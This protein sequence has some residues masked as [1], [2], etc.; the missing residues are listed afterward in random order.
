ADS[1]EC[2]LA[3]DGLDPRNVL[4][5]A[6]H[7]LQTF[8]L[9][10]VQLELQLKELV[11]EIALLVPQLVI[12]QVPY[13]FCFHNRFLNFSSATCLRASQT[14]CARA[15]CATPDAW[16]RLRPGA[17]HLPSQTGSSPGGRLLPNGP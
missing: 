5:Q 17:K 16:L 6:T 3:G 7:L 8:G 14:W 11:L 15:A 13:F 1:G 9:A 12:G 2:T 10:H 4:A